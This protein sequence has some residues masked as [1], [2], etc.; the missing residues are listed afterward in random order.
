MAAPPHRAVPLAAPA[1]SDAEA[2]PAYLVAPAS[3]AV[4]DLRLEVCALPPGTSRQPSAAELRRARLSPAWF[5]E[6][7]L[8]AAGEIVDRLVDARSAQCRWTVHRP[9]RG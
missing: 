7:V 2:R 4:S 8:G 5:K 3:A 1:G 9:V 6:R